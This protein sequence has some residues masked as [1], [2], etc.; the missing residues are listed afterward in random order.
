MACSNRCHTLR[1]LN[2]VEPHTGCVVQAIGGTQAAHNGAILVKN[3]RVR[4]R[5]SEHLDL[6]RTRDSIAIADRHRSRILEALGQITASHLT[7]T[8]ERDRLALDHAVAL[9]VVT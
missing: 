2:R 3:L 6:A 1:Y 4:T 7:Q 9:D 8:S 5:Q